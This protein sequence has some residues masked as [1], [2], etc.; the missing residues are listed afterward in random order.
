MTSTLGPS[1]PNTQ[2][3]QPA[4]GR[5]PLYNRSKESLPVFFSR[6]ALPLLLV[7]LIGIFSAARP[8]TFATVDNL[9]TVLNL[10]SVLTI[11]A[12]GLLLPLIVGELD[13][14][15]A[16]NLGLG[17]ILATGLTSQQGLP[18][19][20]A[21]IISIL[22]CTGVGV[23]NGLLVSKVGINSFIVTIGMST[24]LAG[25]IGAYTLGNVF[26]ENIPA[27]LTGLGQGNIVGV[28]IPVIVAAAVSLIM[29]YLLS[30]TPAGR[31]L[32]AIGGSRDAARLSGI[33]VPRLTIGAFAGAGALAGIAGVVQAGILGSGS[34]TVGPPMLL[35]AYAAVFLGATAFSPGL[36]NVWG[37]VVAV[38]TLQ[39][40]TTGLALL[41]A[42][43]WIEPLF[44]GTALIAAVAATRFLRGRAN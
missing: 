27:E 16:A 34:P 10:Q 5:R 19:V 39:V 18:A 43:F 41:G 35:P 14:S 23:I 7:L 25:L 21:I 36:F 30:Q 1:R 4:G 17:L 42:P 20:P 31:F 32:Y 24:I 44:T 29:W 37:T 9:K 15:V 26:Y 40:G 2:K 33:A 8:E 6:I 12:V 22:A 11:V 3:N 13:L 28:P 38:I